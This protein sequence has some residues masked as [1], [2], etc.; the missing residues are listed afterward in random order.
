MTQL[1]SLECPECT[2]PM[3]AAPV[4]VGEI[5]D[6]AGCGVE[7]EVVALD[8]LR[9]EVAPEIEEDWGE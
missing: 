6:C 5:L 7:L 8:P 3:E 2:S 1:L 4:L 9:V